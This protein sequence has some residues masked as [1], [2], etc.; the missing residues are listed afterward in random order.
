MKNNT[1][2]QMLLIALIVI[3][4]GS[5]FA[6]QVAQ[7]KTPPPVKVSIVIDA[8]TGVDDAAAISYLLTRSDLVNILGITAVAGNTTVENAANNDL[9]LLDA[10]Q[11]TD[12]PVVVGAAAPLVLPASLQGMFVN[13]PDGLWFTSYGFAPHDLSGLSHDAAAFLCSKAQAG[14]TLLAL[15]PLTNVA[16]AV[17]ACPAQ[18][19]L[20]KIVWMGGAKSVN[21]E[22]N[23]PVSVFNPWFDPDAAQIVLQ[24]GVSMV[25]VTTDAARTVTIDPA[26][27]DK[28]A[29]HGNALGKLI[30]PALKQYA[31]LFATSTGRHGKLRVALYDPT[32]AVLAV[33]PDWAT[34]Q[35]GLVMV[36]TQDGIARGQ[37]IFGFSM[38]EHLSMLASDAELSAIAGQAYSNP[39]FDMNAAL[40]AILY[41]QP[42][43][44]QVILTLDPNQIIKEWLTGVTK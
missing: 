29:Q 18:M 43:N 4:L 24:S 13:G 1:L 42:D 16:N 40:G 28:I 36:Q 12:I 23:T 22:G 30:A 37:T 27:F 11:R 8:D 33:H 32:V 17:R 6:T 39:N 19:K 14:V 31:S 44:A 20:Y 35:T 7:A 15:G 2:K 26:I 10:A 38:G 5:G 3:L 21:G 41:R 9:L 25:M 34:P